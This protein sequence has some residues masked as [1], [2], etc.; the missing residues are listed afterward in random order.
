MNVTLTPELERVVK[1]QVASGKFRTAEEV[2][3]EGLRL[4]TTR[5]GEV[6]PAHVVGSAGELEQKLHEGI[7]QL[8]R[9]ERVAAATSYARV[10][11]RLAARGNG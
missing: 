7:G 1:Q 5:G 4:L 11:R 6:A 8:E 10:K 9:G 3:G 2:V